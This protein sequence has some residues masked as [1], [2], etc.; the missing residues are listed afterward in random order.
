MRSK[1]GKD[2]VTEFV[3]NQFKRNGFSAPSPVTKGE[4][5]MASIS[6]V[7]FVASIAYTANWLIV[8]T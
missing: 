1:E 2:G 3:P 8:G 6:I 5:I 4:I 7:I